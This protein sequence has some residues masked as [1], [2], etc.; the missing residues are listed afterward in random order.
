MTKL[1]RDAFDLLLAALDSDRA[2]A[3]E[4]YENIRRK[5]V[6]FFTW[7]RAPFPEDCADE[8][9]NR[10]ARRL[11]EGAPILDVERYFHGVAR[12]VRKEVSHQRARSDAALENLPSLSSAA[13]DPEQDAAVECLEACLQGLDGDSRHLILRYYQGDHRVRIESRKQIAAELHIPLNAL[14][15]RALRLRTRLEGCVEE[16]LTRRPEAR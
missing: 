7:E 13:A 1:T 3:G 12:M 2:R 14:R 16:C 11:A 4:R 10:V 9:I 15:N 8:S 6:K 5:L